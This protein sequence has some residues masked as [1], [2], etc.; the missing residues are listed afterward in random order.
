LEQAGKGTLF[1][2]E[3]GE[4]SPTIQVKLL[5]VLQEREFSRLGSNRLTPLNARVLFATHRNLRDMSQAGTFRK[6]LFFRVNVMNIHV[7]PLRERTEDIPA[8]ARHFLTKYA[9]EY[10]KPVD[11]IVPA[12][13]ELLVEY[14]WPGNVRELEN[15]IQRSVI[16]ANGN[17][18]T[19]AE[20]PEAIRQIAEETVEPEDS[21]G[22]FDDLVRQFKISLAHQ[23]VVDCQGNKTLAA[24]KLKVSRAYLH[25]LIREIDNGAEL[26][27]AVCGD[28]IPLR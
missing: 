18:L 10:E 2:D 25:R 28:R 6:D 8:L 9:K 23:A 11:D 27:P 15:V 19:S 3:V 7:P 26:R 24:K 5:R 12:A 14:A 16:L 13:M 21:A 1:L 17:E 22:S 4:L 20:L